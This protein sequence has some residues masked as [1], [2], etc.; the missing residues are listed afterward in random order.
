MVDEDVVGPVDADVVDF[1]VAVAEFHDTVDD[2]AGIGGQRGFGRFVG[3]RSTGDRP[4]AFGVV[5]RDQTDLFR[6]GGRAD[7]EP[8]AT[9]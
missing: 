6:R 5:L 4:R 9:S 7:G 2:A 8:V 1:V 3:R